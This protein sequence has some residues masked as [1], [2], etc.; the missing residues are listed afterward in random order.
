MKNLES[1]KQQF[2][3]EI[4]NN[5]LVREKNWEFVSFTFF[6]SSPFLNRTFFLSFI[7]S[8]YFSL[9]F[10]LLCHPFTCVLVTVFSILI[11]KM[12]LELYLALLFFSLL[13]FLFFILFDSFFVCSFFPFVPLSHFHCCFLGSLS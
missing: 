1:F 7:L 9:D 3:F 4:N 6:L 13:L 11:Y 2:D 8:I 12:L 5:L 10:L